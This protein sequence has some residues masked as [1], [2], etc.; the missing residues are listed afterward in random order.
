[1]KITELNMSRTLVFL[2]AGLLAGAGAMA[3]KPEGAGNGNQGK[4]KHEQKQMHDQPSRSVQTQE[5]A[6]P[7]QTHQAQ[8]NRPGKSAQGQKD[9]QVRVGGYFNDTQR[10]AVRTYYGEQYRAG[11]CPPGLA[12]KNNGCMPPGQ[13]RKWNVG[14]ALPGD[15]VY[16]SVPQSVIVQLGAPPSGQRYVRVGSDI[17]LLA[18]GTGMVIDAIQNLG[19]L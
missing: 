15:V 10:T 13:A 3:E 17:L 1:M 5:H 11:N 9:T 2:A 16:Y 19:G 18:I 14:R 6:A 7:R 8:A 12:K 4:G